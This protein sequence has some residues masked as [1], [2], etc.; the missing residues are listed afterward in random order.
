MK[1]KREFEKWANSRLKYYS[2]KMLMDSYDVLPIEYNDKCTFLQSHT[3]YPYR[4]VLIEYGPKA[5]DGSQDKAY[6]ERGLVHELMHCIVDPMNYML[7]RN[8]RPSKDEE[9]CVTEQVIEQL[10]LIVWKNDK[11]T[12]IR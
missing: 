8:K 12:K 11:A 9:R 7:Q 10:S 1:S 4:N 5:I 3:N 2:K 6:I